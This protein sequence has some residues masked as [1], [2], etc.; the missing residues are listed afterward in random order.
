ML[1][2]FAGPQVQFAGQELKSS[3]LAVTETISMP[4]DNL[5]KF[6]KFIDIPPKP[7]DEI[8]FLELVRRIIEAI[9]F[10]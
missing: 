4:N 7:F 6:G 10:H 2:N 3:D 1:T 8:L 5:I 9:L